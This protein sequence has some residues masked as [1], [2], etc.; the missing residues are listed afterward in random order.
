MISP[1]IRWRSESGKLAL[2]PPKEPVWALIPAAALQKMDSLPAAA[3]AY[4]PALQ[5][6]EQ[7]VFSIGA[8]RNQQLQLGVQRHLQGSRR[9]LRRCSRN[10]KQP[11]KRFAT[12]SRA[13]ARSP[14]PSRFE[15][16]A[17][18]GKFSAR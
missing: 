18:G 7:I 9:P 10:L 15:R 5:G 13:S 6:A 14:M 17:G 11:P 2:A 16:C 4:V 1:R 12:C 3:K 8:D